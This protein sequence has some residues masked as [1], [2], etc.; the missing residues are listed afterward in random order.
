MKLSFGPALPVGTAGEREYADIWLTRYTT[1]DEVLGTLARSAPVDLAPYEARYVSEKSASLAAVLTIAL[2][3]TELLGKEIAS[4]GVHEALERTLAS[5]EL[6]FEH[7]GKTKVFDLA[8]SVPKDVRVK[9]VDGGVSVEFP[10]R[11]GP[12]G[13][14]RPEALIRTALADSHID[15]PIVRTTRLDLL[16]EDEEGHWSRPV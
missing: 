14:L 7:K 6:V 4:A 16:V 15:V 12:Q 5:G 11:M 1:S 3:R 13:S 9:D 10:V 8:R 2:Y